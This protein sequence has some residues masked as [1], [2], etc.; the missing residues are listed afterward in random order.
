[1]FDAVDI[2]NSNAET[3]LSTVL[4]VLG[5]WSSLVGAQSSNST[6]GDNSQCPTNIPGF[7]HH[8]DCNLL[9]RPAVWTDVIVFYLGNY[10][11]HAA[12][13]I[14]QPG[15]SPV[16]SLY[17]IAAALLFPGAGI[18][19]GLQTIARLAKFAPTELQMAARAGALCAIVRVGDNPRAGNGHP[20]RDP[21]GPAEDEDIERQGQP[22]PGNPVEN[23]DIMEDCGPAEQH[24]GNED[25][26][27]EPE[28]AV[29][30]EPG[31]EPLAPREPGEG[32]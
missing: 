29:K 21:P 13:I 25:K 27:R 1:L 23:G 2:I 19:I 3:M 8:G 9:C 30:I 26:D 32:I 31:L 12:T 24:A 6:N 22:V 4:F 28:R 14:A 15:Q 20:R 5:A 18:Q 17:K 11:A 10:I 16:S 7:F